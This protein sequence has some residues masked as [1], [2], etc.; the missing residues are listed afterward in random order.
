MKRSIKIT[1]IV[2]DVYGKLAIV[3]HRTTQ[4]GMIAL[5]HGRPFRIGPGDAYGAGIYATYDLNSQLNDRMVRLYGPYI[6]KTRVNLDNFLIFDENV[7]RRVY[8]RTHTLE[9]QLR[10]VFGVNKPDP[11]EYL[12]GI[13][14]Y[15]PNDRYTSDIAR[16]FVGS[17][18]SWV[19]QKT[20]G[21]VFTGRQDG[22]VVLAYDYRSML[23][24]SIAFAPSGQYSPNQIVFKKVENFAKESVNAP[25]M[26]LP[27]ME[28]KLLN[29]LLATLKEEIKRNRIS[30]DFGSKAQTDYRGLTILLIIQ[31]R[32]PISNKQL[33]DIMDGIV[34]SVF[35]GWKKRLGDTNVPS[36]PGN[37]GIYSSSYSISLLP[38][39][40]F[41]LSNVEEF[42]SDIR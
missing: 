9:D 29:R 25:S 4:E 2:E 1:R 27:N 17:A 18:F 21:I 32:K 14:G 31:I 36:T 39:P 22:K 5:S 10:Y 38:P 16:T 40:N 34:L 30:L 23:P 37:Y 26:I 28:Q 8:P 11:I 33:E 20:R 35:K 13:S 42:E 41:N 15:T 12:T 19:K 24:I 6:V 7:A 3:Y